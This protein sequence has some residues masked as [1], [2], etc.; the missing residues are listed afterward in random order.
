MVWGCSLEYFHYDVIYFLLLLK[1]SL[2]INLSALGNRQNPA[3]VLE[4]RIYR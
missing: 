1:T 4:I 2:L 3:G